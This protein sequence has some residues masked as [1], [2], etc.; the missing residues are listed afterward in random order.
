[1]D[2]AVRDGRGRPLGAGGT[3]RSGARTP[4]PGAP[5]RGVGAGGPPRAPG[6]VDGAGRTAPGRARR[7]GGVAGGHRLRI[8]GRR[9]GRAVRRAVRRAVGWDPAGGRSR[10]CRSAHPL[11][12][13]GRLRQWR[14]PRG[15]PGGVRPGDGDPGPL[16]RSHPSAGRPDLDAH[17]R[18]PAGIGSG[19]RFGHPADSGTG[20]RWPPPPSC[21]GSANG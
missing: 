18:H 11:P 2:G 3:R 19:R 12:P 10:R 13:R 21:S 17:P 6:R 14:R 20:R 5:P 8:G 15:P 4:R 9:R 1:M 16:P 7:W